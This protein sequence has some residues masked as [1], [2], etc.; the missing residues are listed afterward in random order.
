MFYHPNIHRCE[1]IKINGTQCGSPSLRH[2]KLCYFHARWQDHRL[3]IADSVANIPAGT[4]IG[5]ALNM[6]VLEDANSIQVALMQTI[7]LLLTGQLEHKTA[8]LALYGLQIASSN[9]RRTHFEPYPRSVVINPAAV[10]E[11]LLGEEVWKNSD[12]NVKKEE[13]PKEDKKAEINPL[14]ENAVPMLSEAS[15]ARTS[16]QISDELPPTW[17]EE[18][19]S[20]I[21]ARVQHAALGGGWL[22]EMVH[23]KSP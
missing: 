15:A 19:R 11:T 16:E 22:N 7:S 4:S 5:P 17:R 2:K 21:A 20:E 14:E 23:T 18:L 3:A 10:N 1:H 8:A 12:F 9:L 6:P 13:K